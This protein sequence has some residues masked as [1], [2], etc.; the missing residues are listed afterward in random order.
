M[1]DSLSLF[2]LFIDLSGELIEYVEERSY[3]I[4]SYVLSNYIEQMIPVH[5]GYIPHQ[6]LH[7]QLDF[8]NVDM[9]I[10]R[11][12]LSIQFGNQT[13]NLNSFNANT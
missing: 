1:S 4:N 13:L 8:T 9:T 10:N 3:L 5:E 6:L 2:E 11:N 12:E 7:C